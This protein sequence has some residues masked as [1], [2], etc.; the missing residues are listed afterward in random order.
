[1]VMQAQQREAYRAFLIWYGA[2]NGCYTLITTVNLVYQFTVAHLSPLQMVLVGTVLELTAF[3]AQLPTG[4]IADVFS[5]RLSLIAGTFLVGFGFTIEGSFATFGAILLAQ[6]FWGAGATLLDGADGA[7]LA[8][9]VGEEH[10]ERVY[11]RAGQLAQAVTLLAIP[12]SVILGS[13]RISAPIVVGGVLMMLLAATMPLFVPERAFNPPSRAGHTTGRILLRT[14]RQGIAV[15]RGSKVLSLLLGVELFLG[16]A[17]EGWDRLWQPFFLKSFTLPRPGM[18]HPIVWIGLA[19]LIAAIVGVG[20]SQVVVHTLDRHPRLLG[21][22]T[23]IV[24]QA[25]RIVG[26]LCF[27][28]AGNFVLGLVA[29]WAVG[30]VQSMNQPLYDARFVR[31]ASS[32]VRATV[33]SMR[34][35]VN[36]SGQI[37]GGPAIGAIGNR[38]LRAALITVG[39]LLGPIIPLLAIMRNRETAAGAEDLLTEVAPTQ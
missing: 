2:S 33:L 13:F 38:S 18:L 37:A 14:L 25:V 28:L 36:S 10:L 29:F 8:G 26:V 31:S 23:L 3:I 16:L 1:M 34:G 11:L 27:A 20:L 21:V 24:L 22:T 32:A 6:V 15:V 9:E 19:Q 12:V 7:W 30:A 39:V 17:S 4:V 35:L 5:R